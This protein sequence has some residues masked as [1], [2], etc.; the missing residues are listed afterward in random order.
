MKRKQNRVL[1]ICKI[2]DYLF[3]SEYTD[4]RRISG[5]R[6]SARYCVN[7]LMNAGIEAQLVVVRDNNDIDRE[8]TKFKP[9]HVIIEAVWVV[10]SKF[11][12]LQK[13]HPDVKWI[14]RYHSELPFLSGEGPALDWAIE[15]VKY[16]NV[17]ISGNS[18]TLNRDL[19]DIVKSSHN[20]LYIEK[21]IYL[22]NCYQFETYMRQ[23]KVDLSQI[24][25]KIKKWN[26]ADIACFGAIRPLKNQLLQAAAAIEFGE[27][28]GLDIN[29]HMNGDRIEQNGQ[30]ILRNIQKLF[31]HSPRHKLILHPWLPHDKFLGVLA[32]MDLG[33]QVSFSETFNIVAADMVSVGLPIVVSPDIYWAS[34][35]FK[36]APTDKAKIIDKM[37]FAWNSSRFKLQT[38]NRCKLIKH[39]DHA[40]KTWRAY[41]G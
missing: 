37:L 34:N 14:I 24:N 41:F 15:Y 23:P 16:K 32:S 6:N 3:G 21:V 11:D 19:V 28:K 38:L 31:E 40:S 30:P 18:R 4:H 33:L 8:V 29:F 2:S 17:Y 35:L 36:V 1:F 20:H 7:V 12:I 5:L 9:T 22:P 13:L 39:M 26:S 10:P 27:I 25:P